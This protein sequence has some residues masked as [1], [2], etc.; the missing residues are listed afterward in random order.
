MADDKQG[1]RLIAWNMLKAGLEE[2]GLRMVDMRDRT[3]AV[4]GVE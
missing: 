1:M 4:S 3:A 2:R